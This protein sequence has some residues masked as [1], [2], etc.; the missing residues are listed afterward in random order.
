MTTVLL[1]DDRRVLLD[2]GQAVLATAAVRVITAGSGLAALAIL[3]RDAPD[4]AVIDL[5]MP[6]MDGLETLRRARA[7]PGGA[8]L[9][10]LLAAPASRRLECLAAGA[11]GVVL[12]PLAAGS[13]LNELG[14]FI[15]IRQRL[16]IRVTAHLPAAFRC[17]AGEFT[18]ETKNI[19]LGGAFIRG[20]GNPPLGAA[21]EF[22]L[23]CNG[24]EFRLP[25]ETARVLPDGGYAL[26]FTGGDGATLSALAD[27]LEARLIRLART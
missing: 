21:G 1:V 17:A 25:A 19:S 14:K 12:K 9:T 16:Q 6:L 7:L 27:E 24:R 20:T 13:L 11:N 26:R 22:V 18:G 15:P 4:A 3:Q 23:Q 5:D 2:L 10:L 8:Q